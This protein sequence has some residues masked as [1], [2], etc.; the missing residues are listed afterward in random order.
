MEEIRQLA[1]TAKFK[2]FY[3]MAQSLFQELIRIEG[4]EDDIYQLAQIE[5]KIII[6]DISI[7]T[8]F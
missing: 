4:N 8:P 7:S 1:H 3:L 6:S 2:G 5:N